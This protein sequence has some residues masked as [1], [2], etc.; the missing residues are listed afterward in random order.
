[1]GGGPEEQR[2][3]SVMEWR[4]A[5]KPPAVKLVAAVLFA[6]LGVFVATDAVG[7]SLAAVAA[8]G[9]AASAA[10][11]LVFPVRLRADA[12][13]LTLVVRLARRRLP[14]SQIERVRV[15][16]R[17]RLGVRTELLEIDTGDELHFFSERELGVPPAEALAAL[18]A[19]SRS[20]R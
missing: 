11:D 9:L 8:A 18:A 1:M 16:E 12:K 4:V 6:L 19:L 7:R 3:G 13:G 20:G 17:H 15:D 5:R 10:R 14:W 2:G